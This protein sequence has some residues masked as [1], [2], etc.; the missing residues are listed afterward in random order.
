VPSPFYAQQEQLNRTAL[1]PIGADT[2]TLNKSF[3]DST[4]ETLSG[5][6][7]A[8]CATSIDRTALAA[9]WAFPQCWDT[10]EV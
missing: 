3:S 4:I 7:A 8:C 9:G 2:G 10:N 6:P 1:D 5:I